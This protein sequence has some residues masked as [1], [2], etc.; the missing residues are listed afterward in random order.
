MPMPPW[1]NWG[2]FSNTLQSS[3]QNPLGLSFVSVTSVLLLIGCIS[4]FLRKWTIGLVLVLTIMTTLAAS[5]IQKY[6]FSGR[7][8]LFLVP[9]IFLLIAEGVE[10]IRGTLAN[11]NRI[12]ASFTVVVLILLLLAQPAVSAK[13]GLKNPNMGEHIRPI[14]EYINQNKQSNDIVYIYYG[15]KPAFLYYAPFCGLKDSDFRVGV[16]ART[17][18]E[19]YLKDIDTLKGNG[20]VWFVFSHNCSWCKVDEKVYYLIHLNKIGK[21]IDEFSA[22]G[23]VAYLYDLK[24]S[25]TRQR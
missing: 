10:R 6:P 12:V 9:I 20:R 13:N 21:K 3:F 1:N 19:K 16:K 25:S 17:E 23:A 2:W 4:I 7:L 22:S 18:P 5:G 15:A 14:V 24:N 11:H 8:I